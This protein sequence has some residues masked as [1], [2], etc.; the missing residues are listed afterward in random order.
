[1]CVKYEKIQPVTNLHNK[2][3]WQIQQYRL[4]NFDLCFWPTEFDYN[5]I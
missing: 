5:N 2:L 1:M 4:I 3:S